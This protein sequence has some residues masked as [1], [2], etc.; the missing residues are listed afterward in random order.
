MVEIVQILSS[1]IFPNKNVKKKKKKNPT[2]FSKRVPENGNVHGCACLFLHYKMTCIFL[3]PG[4]ESLGGTQIKIKAEQLLHSFYLLL[5]FCFVNLVT[6][7]LIL[8][9]ALILQI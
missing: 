9:A 2:C 5:I 4:E 6:W 3:G 8:L 7:L 1:Y